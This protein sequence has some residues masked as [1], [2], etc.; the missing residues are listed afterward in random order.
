MTAETSEKKA[1]KDPK[2]VSTES[3]E[4]NAA[5]STK[6]TVPPLVASARRLERLLGGGSATDS[7][8]IVH[9]YTN[10][11]KVLRRWLGTSSGASGKATLSDV[12]SAAKTL[13]NPEGPAAEGRSVLLSIPLDGDAMDTTN[14]EGATTTA[15]TSSAS[16]YLSI[17]SEREVE[18]WLTS[19]AVRLLWRAKKYAEA[20]QL[21]K[22]GVDVAT[23]HIGI[24]ASNVAKASGPSM[25]SMFPLLARLYRLQ[26]LVAESLADPVAT[27][28]LRQDFVKAH[29]TA[30]IR[31]DVDTQATLLNLL[32][33]DLVNASES[34]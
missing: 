1:E 25:S 9:A 5:D 8:S 24:A 29:G 18:A 26:S 11:G 20:F 23:K 27:A 17:A 21:C 12:V 32:L 4:E 6:P 33:R 16:Q 14:D 7:K 22:T 10:P 28:Q 3:K 30:V 19:L 2:A 15:T 31:R 34:E 13:L